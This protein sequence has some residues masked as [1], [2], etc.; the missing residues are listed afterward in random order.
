MAERIA[1]L[2][3][4]NA[5]SFHPVA[6]LTPTRRAIIEERAREYGRDFGTFEAVFKK[7]EASDFLKGANPR[8]W[9]ADFDWIVK[10]E[11]FVK[12]LEGKYD[13]RPQTPENSSFDTDEFFEAALKRSYE[14]I[15][16]KR[17]NADDLVR[18]LKE[19][20]T[21]ENNEK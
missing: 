18:E 14:N 11:N 17:T 5:P 8:G 9:R 21:E 19:K 12:I 3:R 4:E 15:G 7:A 2:F 20:Y 13:N 10:R 1:R 16:K 6:R